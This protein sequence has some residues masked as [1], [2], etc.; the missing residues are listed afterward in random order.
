[1]KRALPWLVSAAFG[2]CIASYITWTYS[3]TSSKNTQ[4]TESANQ[5]EGLNLS[6]LSFSSALSKASPAVVN[7]RTNLS[8]P[9]NHHPLEP[10]NRSKSLGSGVIMTSDGYL[11]TNHHVILVLIVL[12]LAHYF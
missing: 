4:I 7:F 5:I 10:E 3:V 12:F 1:M 6:Q 9:G 2:A 8:E 11:L